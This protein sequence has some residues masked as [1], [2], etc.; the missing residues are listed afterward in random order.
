MLPQGIQACFGIGELA[1]A[2]EQRHHK[3]AKQ[4]AA[5]VELALAK[6]QRCHEA[7]IQTAMSAES[8]LAN[9]CCRHEAA[10]RAA[11]SA[12][13]VLAKKQGCHEMTTREKAL[14]EDA[15]E[16]RCQESA[17][18]TAVL[19]KLALATEQTAVLVDLVLPKLALA[20]DKQRLEETPK[21]QCRSDDKHVMNQYCCLTPLMWQSGASRYDALSLLLLLTP[22]WPRL[23]AMTLQTRHKLRQQQPCHIQR[24]CCP[25]PPAL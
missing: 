2:D 23:N 10:A 20:E 4:A 9:E 16:Q 7:A 5:L 14:A 21:K 25:P 3:A 17:K 11:E 19:T 15:C 8:S 13:L 12:E 1:L 22:S 24:P 18:C 6:E